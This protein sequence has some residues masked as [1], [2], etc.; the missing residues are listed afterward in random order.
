M[1]TGGDESEKEF[2][3]PVAD[4]RGVDD[5]TVNDSTVDDRTVDDRTVVAP[6]PVSDATV[7]DRTVVAP[8][9]AS[10]ATVDDRT[11]AAPR[12]APDSPANDETVIAP[13]ATPEDPGPAP[14]EPSPA[15]E[16]PSAPETSRPASEEP[17]SESTVVPDEEF[18]VDDR[19]VV[20]PGGVTGKRSGR[21]GDVEIV[22]FRRPLQGPGT[23]GTA[24]TGSR[25]HTSSGTGGMPVEEPEVSGRS[26]QRTAE[27]ALDP[28]HRIERAPWEA[29]PE[30]GLRQGIPVVYGPRGEAPSGGSAVGLASADAVQMRIGPPPSTDTA[31]LHQPRPPMP[32]LAKRGRRAGMITLIAYAAAIAISVTGLTV[33]ARIVFG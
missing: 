18:T 4:N 19:T 8:R 30:P 27:E 20:A 11:V 33:I 22:G 16:E 10:D 1:S 29:Q 6:R 32:S 3:G 13:R 25:T 7:D 5:R 23:T 14:E 24:G 28:H 31:P 26:L 21:S 17:A 15:S 12:P 9:P 2:E